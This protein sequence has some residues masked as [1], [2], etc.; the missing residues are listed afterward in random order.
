M[1]MRSRIIFRY[2]ILYYYSHTNYRLFVYKIIIYYQQK[3]IINKLGDTRYM[4]KLNICD[5]NKIKTST[6]V[7][8][9]LNY[10]NRS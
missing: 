9:K 7:G 4:T 3:C 2:N 5:E 6:K 10:K 8:K 1:F